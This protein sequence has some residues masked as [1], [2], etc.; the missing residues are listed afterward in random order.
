M[1]NDDCPVGR[2]HG[3]RIDNLEGWV[4]KMDRKLDR[5]QGWLF[6]VAGMMLIVLA[7]ELVRLVTK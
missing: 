2:E 3:A 4:N 5:I 1:A 6:G 7:T